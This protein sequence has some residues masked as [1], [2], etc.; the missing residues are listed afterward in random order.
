MSSNNEGPLY[1]SGNFEIIMN[2]VLHNLCTLDK[3]DRAVGTPAQWQDLEQ[4]S[5]KLKAYSDKRNVLYLADYIL[6]NERGLI[7]CN[8]ST[9]KVRL[10]QIGRE[11]CAQ[12]LRE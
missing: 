2:H 3:E 10:T 5:N 12:W 11:L 4:L 1:S 6:K 8:K 7:E 9:L